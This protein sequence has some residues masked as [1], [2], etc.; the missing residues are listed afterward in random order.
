MPQGALMSGIIPY[1]STQCNNYFSSHFKPIPKRCYLLLGILKED[2]E[3]NALQGG[4]S[5]RPREWY[6][7]RFKVSWRTISEDFRYLKE[8]GFVDSLPG[9]RG[10]VEKRWITCEGF[11]YLVCQT[12]T[13]TSTYN[14]PIPYIDLSE[15]EK[16]D[17]KIIKE[18]QT[19]EQIPDILEDPTL[20]LETKLDLFLQKRC[21]EPRHR[22]QIKTT[23]RQTHIGRARKEE[24]LDR[25][26][27]RSKKHHIG[28]V[29]NYMLTCLHREQKQEKEL[30]D[31]FKSKNAPINLYF[32]Q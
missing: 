19:C 6:T 23:L 1:R 13:Y 29:K 9:G 5:Q 28:N 32:E 11:E 26:I 10:N 31:F 22:Q 30:R 27:R 12:S 25:I 24:V 16:I 7:N 4:I 21:V 2:Y 15:K 17:N 3:A 14:L 8:L 20:D 18:E